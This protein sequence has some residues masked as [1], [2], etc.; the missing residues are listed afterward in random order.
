MLDLPAILVLDESYPASHSFLKER[1]YIRIVLMTMYSIGRMICKWRIFLS[2][3]YET[4][5]SNYVKLRVTI[6]LSARILKMWFTDPFRHIWIFFVHPNYTPVKFLHISY[7]NLVMTFVWSVMDGAL[8]LFLCYL[9]LAVTPSEVEEKG[10]W[11]TQQKKSEIMR[12]FI[13]SKFHIGHCTLSSVNDC[14]L[15]IDKNCCW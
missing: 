6:S 2:V 4:W 1:F 3:L 7:F 14:N 8:N 13:Q 12:S 15:V 10:Q 11:V 5:H 9:V